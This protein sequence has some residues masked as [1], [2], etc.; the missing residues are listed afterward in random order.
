MAKKEI[1]PEHIIVF[2]AQNYKIFSNIED[3]SYIY[4][5]WKEW[6]IKD[7]NSMFYPAFEFSENKIKVL[8]PWKL[9]I[10]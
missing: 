6:A 3:I 1:Q 8:L 5:R 7:L 4:S 10:N 2:D 9:I